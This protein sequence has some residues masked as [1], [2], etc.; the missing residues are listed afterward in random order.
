MSDLIIFFDGECQLCNGFV[1]FV[2]KQDRR[3]QCRFAAL[4]SSYAEKALDP[5]VRDLKSIV[6]VQGDRVYRRSDG[7]L[8]VVHHLG[9]PWAWAYHLRV[10]PKPLRDGI[11]DI[12]AAMRYR[13]F[14]RRTCRL[15]DAN[16][17]SRFLDVEIPADASHTNQGSVL[18]N[19]DT[20]HDLG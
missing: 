5:S 12:I 9:P 7:V 15:P 14:G 19:Q 11:Y 6:V 20:G 3:A 16:E 17:R 1:D 8:T 13:L 4:Q 18:Q 2:L 10:V